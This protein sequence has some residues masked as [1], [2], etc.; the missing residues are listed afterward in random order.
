MTSRC[1]LRSSDIHC[2]QS[3]RQACPCGS[4]VDGATLALRNVSGML[5]KPPEPEQ[6]PA[7]RR[8]DGLACVVHDNAYLADSAAPGS[9]SVH[10]PHHRCRSGRT[11]CTSRQM[12]RPLARPSSRRETVSWRASLATSDGIGPSSSFAAMSAAPVAPA[13]CRSLDPPSSRQMQPRIAIMVS[14]ARVS[15]K[16]RN[17]IARLDASRKRGVMQHGIAATPRTDR[18]QFGLA[19]PFRWLERIARS[20]FSVRKAAIPESFRLRSASGSTQYNC[21]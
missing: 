7:T 8:C 16:P 14:H 2:R 21:M 9:A 18:G 11:S 15:A 19:L 13:T 10:V 1:K 17:R 5:A 20:C 12:P 3:P 6:R 4:A